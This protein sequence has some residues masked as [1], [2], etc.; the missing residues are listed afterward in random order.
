MKNLIHLLFTTA[1]LMGFSAL[2]WGYVP[3]DV[4][5]DTKSQQKKEKKQVAQLRADCLLATKQVDLD[6]NN[7]RARLLNGGDLWWDLENGRYIVPKVE[8]GSG[9]LPV[10]SIFAGAVW[11]G[12]TST[13]GNLKVAAVTYRDN[14]AGNSD[15][16]PG[17][18]NDKGV[19]TKAICDNWDRFFRVT[20]EEVREHIRLWKKLGDAYT[21][22]M[23]PDGVKYYP[24]AG[25]PFFA[26]QYK[27]DVPS[28]QEDSDYS[29][30]YWNVDND[31]NYNPLHGD[32]PYIQVRGC[33]PNSSAKAAELVPDEMYFWIYNDAGG[34]HGF[35][36]ANP[37]QM[38]VQVQAFAYATQDELNNM[39]FYRYRLINE[40]QTGIGDTYFAMWVDPDL[41][42]S[43]DDYIGCDTSRSLMYEYNQD[44]IDG[45]SGSTCII[46][47]ESTPTYG[48]NIPMVGV[49]YFRGPLDTFGVEL[50]MSSFTYFNNPSIG[51]PPNGT[52]DPDNGQQVYYYLTGR[53]KDGS[54]VT[55]GG[56]GFHSG[57][58]EINYV[59][60][61]APD[62]V[63][64]WSMAQETLPY[65]DRRTIQASGPFFLKRG[66]VNELII[67][68]VWVPD[69][70]HP[71]P[72]LTQI[73]AAD[74]KAQ[75]LFDNCF[76]IL[77]G[78]DAP[79]MSIIELDEQ[80]IFILTNDTFESNNRFLS[81]EEKVQIDLIDST[82]TKDSTYNFQGYRVYQLKSLQAVNTPDGRKDPSN[83]RLVFQSDLEDNVSKIFNWKKISN[84][85]DPTG[86]KISIPILEVEAPN[87]GLQSS[88]LVTRDQFTG[89]PLINNQKYF[90]TVVAYA[91]N[92]YEEYDPD[93][94]SG[95]N[96]AYIEGRGNVA[97]YTV[98]PRESTWRNLNAVYG[99]GF[100]VTQVSGSGTG[101][102]F[103]RLTDESRNELLKTTEPIPIT[104]QAGSDPINLKV[105]NPIDIRG[106]DYVLSIFDNDP[107]D[108]EL[109]INSARYSLINTT[110]RDTIATR[111]TVPNT[112]EFIAGGYGVSVFVNNV[113]SPGKE[114]K[115]E[116]NGAVG[117]TVEF[118]HPG[119]DLWFSFYEDDVYTNWIQTNLN[120]DPA[121]QLDPASAFSGGVMSGPFYP[122]AL[123]SSIQP[124][125][126]NSLEFTSYA[127]PVYYGLGP[128]SMGNVIANT[129]LA[130]LPN[131]DII[132]TSD[133]SKWSRC[134]V[135]E[136]YNLWYDNKYAGIP[137]GP[138][139]G[140]PNM[141]IRQSP[142]VT[143]YDK[144][145]D[146]NPDL[147]PDEADPGFA[148]FP[149][150]A[151]NVVTGERLN[152]F[153]GENSMFNSTFP[154]EELGVVEDS[155]YTPEQLNRGADMMWN[156]FGVD[157]VG[158]NPETG[159]PLYYANGSHFIYVTNGAYDGCQSLYNKVEFVQSNPSNYAKVL[160]QNLAWVCAPK[161][162][163]IVPL[164]SYAEGLIPD[165]VVIS[166][167][168]DDEYRNRVIV[169]GVN[170][171]N[172]SYKW[173]IGNA[174]STVVAEDNVDSLLKR[175]VAVPNPYRGLSGYEIDAAQ[176]I[177]K[178]T[179]LPPTCTISIYTLNGKFVRQYDVNE[180]FNPPRFP[181]D[182]SIT[183]NP[184][185]PRE[186][187]N[188]IV[189]WDLDNFAG[190]PVSSGVYL[191]YIDAPGIGQK[192]IKWFG[193]NRKFDPS[194]F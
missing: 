62:D 8:P 44:A 147:D 157:V 29:G 56:S 106:G 134:M 21:E 109:D 138:V 10:S 129:N 52:G 5:K 167:R 184:G 59:F 33:T 175:V 151:I 61:S 179:N 185:A 78:P 4:Y 101:G 58:R 68:V 24:G 104:Y 47:N 41:G 180:S 65:A 86:S 66:V 111:N 112:G 82:H 54:P 154:Y 122:F 100:E 25:N 164:T 125:E 156:P 74:D 40:A 7:V 31:P 51:D 177:V 146:G 6:V 116:S 64:G 48:K 143:K 42:C 97:V 30:Y 55:Y 102:N 127:R 191:I 161:I 166:V 118:E 85:A 132:L 60:P 70:P 115:S 15:F 105:I 88:F 50:G 187:Y 39:T 192:V 35:S 76:D 169:P 140:A 142:S 174:A 27:F 160:G 71:A 141:G 93:S 107:S 172:P 124:N 17:P 193:I 19:T 181:D 67:G 99:Q 188:T 152:I 120:T 84:P 189:E 37:I 128:I 135:I 13:D 43:D 12:G 133:K 1:F 77:D 80:A 69:I 117:Q 144:D 190:I 46:F 139:G 113:Q 131:V 26:E 73:R 34:A 155:I 119:E 165:K 36:L 75:G 148:W 53:W 186:Y 87:T 178:I 14:E 83:A 121:Y 11:L 3:Y 9:K 79:D 23:I 96:N 150:Y 183:G 123:G 126:S 182:K 171:G 98:I 162:S 81:Y 49:D 173:T 72:S 136:T 22:D 92:Q 108:G 110:T 145:G 95:Q 170:N 149:G 63:N 45:N 38:E 163:E 18:L 94:L 114:N 176:K 2:S 194:I 158:V 153:F 159:K 137:V 89:Q 28:F 90:Y 168:V 16:Y 91:F 57:G 32:F 20:G 103:L 130:E